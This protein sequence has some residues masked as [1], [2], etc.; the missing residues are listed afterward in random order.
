MHEGTFDW[1]RAVRGFKALEARHGMDRHTLNVFCRLQ[2]NICDG[3]LALELLD[4]I[5]DNPDLGVW[6]TEKYYREFSAW[7]RKNAL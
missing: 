1:P 5:G 2:E 4:R 6:R 3:P 7:V